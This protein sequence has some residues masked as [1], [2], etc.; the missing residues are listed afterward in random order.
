MLSPPSPLP[1]PPHLLAQEEADK[2]T[3]PHGRQRDYFHTICPTSLTKASVL[4][5]LIILFY[6]PHRAHL[7]LLYPKPQMPNSKAFCYIIY[8]SPDLSGYGHMAAA[9]SA[10][11]RPIYGAPTLQAYGLSIYGKSILYIS[12]SWPEYVYHITA[13]GCYTSFSLFY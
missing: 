5:Y 7:P 9:S 1:R 13:K 8:F 11:C 3:L 2:E 6:S 12:L 4:I 10:V